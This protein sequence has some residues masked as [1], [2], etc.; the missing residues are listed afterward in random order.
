[1][2]SYL[3]YITYGTQEKK[4]KKFI[5]DIVQELLKMEKLLKKEF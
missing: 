5:K 2:P 1:M 4:E 3:A